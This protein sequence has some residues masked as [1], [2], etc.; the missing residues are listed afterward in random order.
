MTPRLELVVDSRVRARQGLFMGRKRAFDSRWNPE[1]NNSGRWIPTRYGEDG[2]P[3]Q[4]KGL[5]GGR[6]RVATFASEEAC[7]ERCDDLNVLG[8]RQ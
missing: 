4:D 2:R 6:L 7:Q 5:V 8:G 1:R 3:F